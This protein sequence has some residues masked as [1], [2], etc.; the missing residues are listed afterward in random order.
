MVVAH[1]LGRPLGLHF[2]QFA[3]GFPKAKVA[4]SS[5]AG[6]AIAKTMKNHVNTGGFSQFAWCTA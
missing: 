1:A 2:G 5:L 6:G 3:P 4:S